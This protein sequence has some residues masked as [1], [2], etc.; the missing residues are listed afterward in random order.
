MNKRCYHNIPRAP[1]IPTST[2]ALIFPFQKCFVDVFSP[3]KYENAN[4]LVRIR[5]G[6]RDL[7]DAAKETLHGDL[8]VSLERAKQHI[9][10]NVFPRGII[11]HRSF[12]FDEDEI[13]SLT[14]PLRNKVGDTHAFLPARDAHPPP[15]SMTQRRGAPAIRECTFFLLLDS[16]T[17][18]NSCSFRSDTSS[19]LTSRPKVFRG[20]DDQA[21]NRC[22][23]V[24]LGT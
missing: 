4:N 3:R 19:R 2:S 1:C 5:P 9:R 13:R 10:R 21:R 17:A 12:H 14:S 7:V 20:S 18:S 8:S 11:W 15:F 6:D 16:T 24:I 22:T 23:S